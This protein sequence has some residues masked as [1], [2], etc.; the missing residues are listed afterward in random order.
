MTAKKPPKKTDALTL[1][2]DPRAKFL[3][4][5]LS[6]DGHQTITGVIESAVSRLGNDR[7]VKLP[8]GDISLTAAIERIWSPV[9]SER[10]VNLA[11]FTPSLLTHEE[12]CIRAVLEGADHIFF[13]K[14]E[15]RGD[16][17]FEYRTHDADALRGVI[18][19]GVDGATVYVTP[20]RR[21]IKLAW[22]LIRARAVELAEKGYC[23]DL[24]ASEVESFIGKPLSMISPDIKDPKLIIQDDDGVVYQGAEKEPG[25][26]LESLGIKR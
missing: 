10:V 15:I 11:L 14:F 6:R 26:V 23:D 7:K 1:R 9:E 19:Q 21:V 22:D 17:D 5:L 16:Q 4:E 20:K 24:V 13:N 18:L 3:I 8:G 12:G 2:L 25:D